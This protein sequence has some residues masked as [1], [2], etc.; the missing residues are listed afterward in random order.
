MSEGAH[1]CAWS[2]WFVKAIYKSLV[3]CSH[4]ECQRVGEVEVSPG[5]AGLGTSRVQN[6]V[7]F[8]IICSYII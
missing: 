1:S 3:T 5:A 8:E 7:R 4:G 2:C 6:T